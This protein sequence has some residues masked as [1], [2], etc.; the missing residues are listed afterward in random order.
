MF[1]GTT[2]LGEAVV[3][4]VRYITEDMEIQQRLLRVQMIANEL[5]GTCPGI[6]KCVVYQ[7]QCLP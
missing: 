4:V 5:R 1:D 3:I 6:D 7:L 2:H